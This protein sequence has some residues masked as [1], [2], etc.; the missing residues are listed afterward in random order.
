MDASAKIHAD[1]GARAR[2]LIYVHA[3]DLDRWHCQ[4][5]G[6][7]DALDLHNR[8]VGHLNGIVVDQRANQPVYLVIAR[9]HG[10]THLFLVPVGDAWFDQGTRA[11][12]VDATRREQIPF[13]PEEFEQMKP[14]QA[15][16]YER[17]VLA[18]CCPEVGFHHDGT[19][20]YARLEQFT[21]P[22][23]LRAA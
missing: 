15:D 20:D 4:P 10:G 5:L 7:T 22:P 2:R 3:A 1:A 19:P 13:D 12:R 6:A 11:I 17:R 8:P 21:C 16:E 18:A 23:W 14:E 9:Q